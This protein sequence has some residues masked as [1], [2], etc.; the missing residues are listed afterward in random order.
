MWVHLASAAC[1]LCVRLASRRLV[2]PQRSHEQTFWFAEHAAV[3][4]LLCGLCLPSLL[5]AMRD[6]AHSLDVASH[7]PDTWE[8]SCLPLT[9]TVWLHAYHT[10][11]YQMSAQDAF[12]HVLFVSLLALP[13]MT[14][15]W[16]A[17]GNAQVFWICGLPGG[18]TYALLAAQRCGHLLRVREKTVTAVVNVGLRAPGILLC[19]LCFAYVFLWGGGPAPDAPAWACVMQMSLAPFNAIHYAR[20]SVQRARRTR[21]CA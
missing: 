5:A 2:R 4:F 10:A 7:P 19:T 8:G 13:G 11:C 18:V 21:P 9:L 3:N 16:G 14:F 17:L 20:Q 12:H 6:P 1:L 15:E